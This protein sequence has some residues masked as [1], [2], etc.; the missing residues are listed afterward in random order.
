MENNNNN[1]QYSIKPPTFN[2]DKFEYWKDS[3]PPTSLEIRTQG[4]MSSPGWLA[5]TQPE[6]H[7][8]LF[9]KH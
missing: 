4:K 5:L 1:D 7:T 6:L 3:R 2:G 9:K 8:P